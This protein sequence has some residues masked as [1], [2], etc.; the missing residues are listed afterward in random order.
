MRVRWIIA[1]LSIGL[2]VP[3]VSNAQKDPNRETPVERWIQM[4]P[5]ERQRALAKLPPA[6]RQR[7]LERIRQYQQLSPEE[8]Q[9]LRQRYDRFSEL[10]ADQQNQA[11]ALFRQFR[12]LPDDRRRVMQ[13]ELQ[14]L[15][16]MPE[17]ER[18]KRMATEDFRNRFSPSEKLML[19]DLARAF[20]QTP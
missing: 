17:S 13:R 14:Q 1:A 15:R 10:P 7:I 6:R 9:M 8:R 12:A 18:Q 2:L 3:A 4:T 11:R 19:Q 16:S 5:A 20:N